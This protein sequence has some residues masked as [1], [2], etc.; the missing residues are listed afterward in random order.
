[1]SLGEEVKMRFKFALFS[2]N[3]CSASHKIPSWIKH[4]FHI[5]T[6]T[7]CSLKKNN[8]KRQRM[9]ISSE[10]RKL[11]R[12]HA[13]IELNS[14]WS[15]YGKTSCSKQVRSSWKRGG[16]AQKLDEE[17][18]VNKQQCKLMPLKKLSWTVKKIAKPKSKQFS[19]KCCNE[20]ENSAP[21]KRG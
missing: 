10:W 16:N 12:R 21:K 18:I 13:G 4:H 17:S 6:I 5:K 11:I 3:P 7:A 20:K 19:E 2:S 9:E 14:P 1:M 15:F 8:L